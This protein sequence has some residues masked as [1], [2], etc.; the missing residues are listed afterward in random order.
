VVLDSLGMFDAAA[1]APEQL[2]VAVE[3]SRSRLADHPLPP[4]DEIE[5]VVVLGAGAAGL[6]GEVV[7]EVAGPLMPVPLLVHKGYG[8]PNFVGPSTL[9]LAVSFTGDTEETVEAATEAVLAGAALVSTSTGGRLAALAHTEGTL[10]LPVA[11]GAPTD[12]S[13]LGALVAPPLLALERVGL[14][15]GGGSWIG[16]AIDQLG[17]RRDELVVV[18]NAAHQLAHRLARA[19]PLVY[20]GG[21]PGGTAASWWK[22]QFNANA[23]VPAFAGR[24]PEAGHDDLAGWGQDGDVTRQIMQ[25]V[26]LRH[27]FEHPQVARAFGVLDDLLGEVTGRVHV[28]EAAGEGMLA[29]LLDLA[30]FGTV[31]SLYAATEQGVDPGPTPALDEIAFRLSAEG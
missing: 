25:L 12:R 26:L 1:A 18:G 23:K 5:N 7:R 13:A 11:A 19:F 24:L 22:A 31:A 3:S 27:D 9:V 15:P 29:Q 10:H 4:H 28:V 20:G 30:L 16:A 17:R 6:A 8:L 21:G 14:F 2:A